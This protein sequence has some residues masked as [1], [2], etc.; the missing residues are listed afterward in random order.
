MDNSITTDVDGAFA[1]NNLTTGA[2]YSVTPMKNDDIR[3]GV[4]T[5]DLVAI[6]KHILKTELL[7][8]PYKIIAADANRSRTITTLDLVAVRKVILVVTNEFPGNTSWRFIDKTQILDPRDPFKAGFREVVNFNNIS[9]ERRADFVAIKVGDVTGDY[10]AKGIGAVDQRTFNGTFLL[11]TKDV[12]FTAGETVTAT[13]TSNEMA[14]ILG[15]QFTLNFDNKVIDFLG[16]K[17]GVAKEENFGL[18]MVNDGIITASWAGD[19]SQNEIFTLEFT[20]KEEGRLSDVLNISSEYTRAEA[21]GENTEL[22]QV[23]FNF[24]GKVATAEFE[25]YQNT[26]NPFKGETVVGFNM[27]EAAKAT[28]TVSDVSGKILKVVNGS[29]EKGYNEEVFQSSELGTGVFYYQLD[30]D[31]FT[32]TKKMIIIE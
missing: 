30:S 7:D 13:F 12:E 26:P 14:H 20:A 21:Y 27:P 28:I 32:A 24:G 31:N 15:Y 19:A 17:E 11:N 16:I 9:G 18:T 3:N 22:K 8:S 23:A 5:L 4:S 1:F 10:S 25:L 6:R 29:Y 2:D